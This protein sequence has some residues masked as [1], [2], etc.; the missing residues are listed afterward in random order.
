MKLD[1][2]LA[3][4]LLLLAAA[5]AARAQLP[6]LP[7][8]G[9]APLLYVRFNG[10]PGAKATIYRGTD[11]QEF[12]L[13]VTVGLRPGY[14]YRVKLTGLLP[15]D[16]KAVFFPTLQVCG[17]L[18]GTPKLNP[19]AYPAPVIFNELDLLRVQGG[20]LVSRV[21]YLENPERAVAVA[22]KPGELL[23]TDVEPGRDPFAVAA[24]LGRPVLVVRLGERT[25]ADEELARMAVPGTV[26]FPGERA[27]PPPA[28]PPMTPF[29]CVRLFDPIL[30]PRPPEEECLRDGGDVGVP[31]GFDR[32]GRL[33]GVGPSDTVAEYVDV[34]GRRHIVCS[35][36]ICVCVPRYGAIRCE[37][38]LALESTI[39]EAAGLKS[40][41]EQVLARAKVPSKEADQYEQVVAMRAKKKPSGTELAQ[42]PG[43]LRALKVLLGEQIEIGPLALVGTKKALQLTQVQKTK[44]LRQIEFAR[45]LSQTKGPR[46]VEQAVA[47][48]VVGN[49]KGLGEV[50][51]VV[52]TRD[53]TICCCEEPRLPDKP[54]LLIKCADRGSAQVGDVVTFILKYSNQGG[55]PIRDVAVEDSLTGRLEYVPGSARSD[56][57]AVFTTQP[58]EAGSVKLRWEI[59]GQLPPG[60][61]GVVT[62]QA[63]IR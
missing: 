61:S 6:P 30:G 51:G 58:N 22:T 55:L 14:V 2:S 60:Q 12:S 63:R 53:F 3:V 16:P 59:G 32:D 49:V 48:V 27:L 52:E 43:T 57:D 62:F 38:P 18:Q 10:P 36:R 5:P 13:P 11:G 45:E 24:E 47:A 40:L 1:R 8:G 20:A 34:C 25:Y 7:P 19:A 33:A 28:A 46:G 21:V 44:L 31:A 37:V 17:T 9:P 26:L 39:V 42:G 4:L 15:D 50:R 35:N 54:L 56:R 41:Q 23:E 29:R